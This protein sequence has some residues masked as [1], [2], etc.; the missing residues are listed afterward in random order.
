[1]LTEKGK[2][3]SALASLAVAAA[4]NWK[5]KPAMLDGTPIESEHII[6]FDFRPGR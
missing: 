2:V 4:R 3:K 1:M 5:F 6:V